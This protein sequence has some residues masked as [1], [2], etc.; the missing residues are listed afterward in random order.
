[1]GCHM[2]NAKS[3]SKLTE[4]R[5]FAIEDCQFSIVQ[6][7]AHLCVSRSYVFELIAEKKIRPV[8]LG[9][10]TLIQGD[11]LRRFMRS[12]AAPVLP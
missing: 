1:M 4:T 8:R 7:A 5:H 9:R 10:R 2:P 12:L 11:E 6:A 3:E